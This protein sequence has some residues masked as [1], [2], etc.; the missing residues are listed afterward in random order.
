MFI[1]MWYIGDMEELRP[2]DP[3]ANAI[4][5]RLDGTVATAQLCSTFEHPVSP[6]AVSQWRRRGIPAGYLMVLEMLRPDVFVLAHNGLP[7][8]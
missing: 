4:I 3:V 6:S 5:D 8:D 2:I 7:D 1:G